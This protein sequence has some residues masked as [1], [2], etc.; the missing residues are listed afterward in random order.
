MALTSAQKV[1]VEAVQRIDA[2]YHLDNSYKGSP[3]EE[4]LNNRQLSVKPLVD[5]YLRGSNSS[6]GKITAV[7]I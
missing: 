2:M 1:A 7:R 3:A 6:S 5:A 4:I